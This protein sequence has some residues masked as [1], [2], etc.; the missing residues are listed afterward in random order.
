MRLAQPRRIE[1]GAERHD[2]QNGKGSDPVHRPAERFQ[3]RGVDPMG[4]LQDHQHRVLSSHNPASCGD[5]SAS[6]VYSQ[7]RCGISSNTG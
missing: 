6:S 2:E 5:V 1:L 4:I 3:A 7:R